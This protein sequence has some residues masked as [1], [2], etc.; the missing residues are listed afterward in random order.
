[1]STHLGFK[2]G[3]S[4]FAFAHISLTSMDLGISVITMISPT[5]EGFSI[6]SDTFITGEVISLK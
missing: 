1:M 2:A 5:A 6:A 4:T 3:N